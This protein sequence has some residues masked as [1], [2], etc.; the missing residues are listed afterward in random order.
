MKATHL[1]TAAQAFAKMKAAWPWRWWWQ[2]PG[3]SG[4]D[5]AVICGLT[6]RLGYQADDILLA[7]LGFPSNVRLPDWC[8]ALESKISE[9]SLSLLPGLLLRLESLMSEAGL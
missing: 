7:I 6:E 3:G 8:E 1:A 4:N 2:L 5:E 9:C